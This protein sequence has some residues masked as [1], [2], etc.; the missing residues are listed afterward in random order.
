[1]SPRKDSTRQAPD[2][3]TPATLNASEETSGLD[4][5]TSSTLAEYLQ[6]VPDVNRSDLETMHRV[7]GV[8]REYVSDESVPLEQRAPWYAYLRKHRLEVDRVLK[9]VTRELTRV[10][11]A[12]GDRVRWGPLRLGWRAQDVRYPVNE[13]GN[14]VDA[15]VQAFLEEW[16]GR[17]NR[18]RPG[19]EPIIVAVPEHLE[20]VPKA[21]ASAMHEGAGDARRFYEE[22]KRR[23]LRTEEARAATVEVD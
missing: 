18:L 9:P 10:M 7:A 21:L 8:L 15:D 14:W 16:R 12:E 11:A 1:M 4:G 19:D 2:A 5:S 22:L 23:R 13:A 6:G 17:L 20:V 3:E